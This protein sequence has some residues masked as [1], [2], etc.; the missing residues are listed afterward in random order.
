MFEIIEE[1][2]KRKRLHSSLKYELSLDFEMQ[3]FEKND[4]KYEHHTIKIRKKYRSKIDHTTYISRCF[5]G[6]VNLLLFE[7]SIYL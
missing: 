6:A 5:Y 2:Y 7:H 3:W 1:S 4:K